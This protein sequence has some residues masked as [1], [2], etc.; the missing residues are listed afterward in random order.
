[1]S[2]LSPI[3]RRALTLFE[4]SA[5]AGRRGPTNPEIAEALGCGDTWAAD[6]VAAL[7][8]RGFIRIERVKYGRVVEIA[9]TGLRTAEPGEP[10]S[11]HM[12]EGANAPRVPTTVLRHHAPCTWCG[13]RPDACVCP[14][15]VAAREGAAA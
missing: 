6:V 15:G 2:G 13:S 10:V 7:R 1:M 8:D 12:V 4:R 14:D 11:R 5:V 3:E 9:S